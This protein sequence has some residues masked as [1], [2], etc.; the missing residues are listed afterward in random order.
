ML[1]RRPLWFKSSVAYWLGW[2]G[3]HLSVQSHPAYRV[4]LNICNSSYQSLNDLTGPGV[5]AKFV[6]QER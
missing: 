6:V 1:G 4:T 5:G 2:G 3:L